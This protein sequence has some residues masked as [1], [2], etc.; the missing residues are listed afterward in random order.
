[1][2]EGGGFRVK[3]VPRTVAKSVIERY[4]YSHTYPNQNIAFGAFYN[5]ELLGVITYGNGPHVVYKS[6]PGC[7]H[8]RHLL[9]LMRL[10][11]ADRAPRFMESQ[12]IATTLR[13]MRRDRICRVVISYADPE[14]GHI[15]TIYQASN[16][17][18]IGNTK[19]TTAFVMS[20]G[21]V[22]HRTEMFRTNKGNASLSYLKEKVDPGITLKKCSPKYRYVYPVQK[23]LRSSLTSIGLPYPKHT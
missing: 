16:W 11:M 18:Y 23:N 10:W 2:S 19:E 9:V 7:D 15:G 17:I 13:L 3:V 5:G 20:N 14:Q 21:A 8:A 1:M 4:H 6:I 12:A 22:V